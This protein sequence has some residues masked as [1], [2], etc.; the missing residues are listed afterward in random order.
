MVHAA[1]EPL[2]FF[3]E[4]D[5]SRLTGLTRGQLRRWHESGLFSPINRRSDSWAR[6][7]LYDFRD[8]VGLRVIARF[9][10][11]FSVRYLRRVNEYLRRISD[12]PWSDLVLKI[13]GNELFV[14]ESTGTLTSIDPLGQTGHREIIH[15]RQEADDTIAEI[16]KF[17]KRHPEDEGQIQ[18]S[19]KI[20]SNKPVLKGTRITVSTIWA[21]H[22]SG[23]SAE[24]IVKSF[25][26]L[27]AKDV[28]EVI[29]YM[30]AA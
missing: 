29:R 17:R 1:K 5:V 10:T 15:L 12:K 20:Q 22:K 27:T 24:Q 23:R 26:S 13:A 25:P 16:D 30:N 3:D 19:R 28:A 2:L 7:S 11:R 21:F 18:K 4:E 6:I 9:R 14:E 8:L